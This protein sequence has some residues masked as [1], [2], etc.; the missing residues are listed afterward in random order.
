MPFIA[1]IRVIYKV[2][3]SSLYYNVALKARS[4]TIATILLY[5]RILIESSLYT[6]IAIN[7]SILT[8]GIAVYTK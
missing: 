4:I 2:I 7:I 8:L 1:L 6:A 3:L 5:L